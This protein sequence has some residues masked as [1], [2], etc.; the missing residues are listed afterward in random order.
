MKI[1]AG[2]TVHVVSPLPKM[3]CAVMIP[4]TD[5]EAYYLRAAVEEVKLTKLD[6]KLAVEFGIIHVPED[7][8]NGTLA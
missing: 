7:C 3:P 2:T 8:P 1:Y 6:L 5:Q 4:V